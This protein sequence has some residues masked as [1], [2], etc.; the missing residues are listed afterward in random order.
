M[1]TVFTLAEIILGFLGFLLI[2]NV[3][4]TTNKTTNS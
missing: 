2:Q 4:L 3:Q 1:V